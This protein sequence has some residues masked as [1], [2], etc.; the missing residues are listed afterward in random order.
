MCDEKTLRSLEVGKQPDL[1]VLDRD[2]M[3]VPAAGMRRIKPTAAGPWQA[4]VFA[5]A[6][7]RAFVS[8]LLLAPL[9]ET[10][11]YLSLRGPRNRLRDLFMEGR[12]AGTAL[13]WATF[14]GVS[15][16]VSFFTNWLTVILTHAG[17]SSSVGID[18]IA[19]YSAS[20]MPGGLVLPVFTRWWHTNNVLLGSIVAAVASC[21]CMGFVLP[22]VYNSW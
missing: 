5:V 22:F 2:Y 21:I 7:G 8:V 11:R 15:F 3:T 14:I 13:L 9:Q 16:T 19:V 6:G 4:S 1:V 12:A 18:A 10:P 17:K 20:A